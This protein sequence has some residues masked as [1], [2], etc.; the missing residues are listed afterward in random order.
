MKQADLV[1]LFIQLDDLQWDGRWAELDEWFASLDVNT[2]DTTEVVGV[3]RFTYVAAVK[4]NRFTE[5]HN[6]VERARKQY[7]NG[8]TMLKGLY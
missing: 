5:W 7:P 2:A 6:L 1:K 3:L 4:E 8:D